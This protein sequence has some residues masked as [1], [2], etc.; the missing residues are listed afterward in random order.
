MWAYNVAAGFSF[1]DTPE[2]GVTLSVVTNAGPQVARPHLQAGADLAWQLRDSGAVTY[3]SVDTVLARI[4]PETHGPVLLVEPADNIGAGAPGD[5][6]GVLRA[7][8]E[9]GAERALVALNDP[10]A[11]AELDNVPI[12]SSARLR[13]GG[14]RLA[15]GCR[16]D[17]S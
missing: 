15:A 3:P 6:T 5:G 13:L 11:V 16:P 7:L 17:R 4:P 8:L 14:T 12:G 2:S 9:R 10:L 1:A